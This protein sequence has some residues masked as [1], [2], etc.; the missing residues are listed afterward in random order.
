MSFSYARSK[1]LVF[2]LLFFD[3]FCSGLSSNSSKSSDSLVGE[4][5]YNIVTTLT[6]PSFKIAVFSSSD[7]VSSD[8]RSQGTWDSKKTKQLAEITKNASRPLRVLDIGL[9]YFGLSHDLHFH[10]RFNPTLLSISL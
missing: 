1:L 3:D 2:V 5:D 10:C 6:T 8:I 7:Y 4:D 9:F